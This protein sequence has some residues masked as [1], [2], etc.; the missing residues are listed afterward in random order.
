MERVIQSSRSSAELNATLDDI[1]QTFV[2]AAT[3][4]L[5]LKIVE[6]LGEPRPKASR[7]IRSPRRAQ[8]VVDLTQHSVLYRNRTIRLSRRHFYLLAALVENPAQI[9]GET[10]VNA[11]TRSF[12]YGLNVGTGKLPRLKSELMMRLRKVVKRA[13]KDLVETVESEL[14]LNLNREDVQLITPSNGTVRGTAEEA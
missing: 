14:R 12:G 11:S 3:R 8:L 4:E 2:V 13:P 9:V 6:A 1:R 10:T 5:G 7:S